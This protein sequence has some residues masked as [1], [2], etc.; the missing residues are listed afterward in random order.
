MKSDN[1]SFDLAS[2]HP[3]TRLSAQLER[4]NAGFR[5]LRAL[6]KSKQGVSGWRLATRLG[7]LRKVLDEALNSFHLLYPAITETMASDVLP[8]EYPEPATSL[9]RTL[10]HELTSARSQVGDL[11]EAMA[12]QPRVK[13]LRGLLL[14]ETEYYALCMEGIVWPDRRALGL[15]QL[16]ELT[17]CD[18]YRLFHY[19]DEQWVG[20]INPSEVPRKNGRTGVRI[21][22]PPEEIPLT[23]LRP[24]QREFFS[25]NLSA[26][27]SRFAES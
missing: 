11:F 27:F 21:G 4:R 13:F 22:R 12:A 8:L 10:Y 25:R 9:Y 6:S 20:L 1:A 2:L 23:G 5:G 19:E 7:S 16:G 26:V 15:G 18:L 24:E 17:D 3:E 14:T